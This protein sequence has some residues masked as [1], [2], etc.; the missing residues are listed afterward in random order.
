MKI[1]LEMKIFKINIKI[2]MIQKMKLYT[3]L[4]IIVFLITFK[5][6][7]QVLIQILNNKILNKIFKLINKI[8]NYKIKIYINKKN[9]QIKFLDLKA[10][11]TKIQ[12]VDMRVNLQ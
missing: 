2:N 3:I 10:N 12:I 4:K 5:K 9:N 8:L 7:N 1:D 6:N 11:K